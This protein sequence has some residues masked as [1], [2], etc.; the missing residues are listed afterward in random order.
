MSDKKGSIAIENHNAGVDFYKRRELPMSIQTSKVA[1]MD[2]E[3]DSGTTIGG[4]SH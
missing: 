2:A 1:S 3:R 4:Y